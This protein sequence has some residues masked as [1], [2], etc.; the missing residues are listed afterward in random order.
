MPLLQIGLVAVGLAADAFAVSVVEG[1]LI[2]ERKHRHL[3]R[4]SIMFGLF[5]GIMPVLGWTVGRSFER[6]IGPYDH[7]FAFGVLGCL[8]AKMI[9]DSF[10]GIE[11]EVEGEGSRGLRLGALAL[12]TSIDAL[13]VGI[14]VALLDH[15][16]WLPAAG[17]GLITAILCGIGVQ[18]GDRIGTRAGRKAELVGGIVL[19]GLGLKI[20]AEHLLGG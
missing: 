4:L 7:W 19:V 5:Q 16:I 1:V 6:W 10:L 15:E 17:I 2:E 11:S 20:L 12:A 3:L 9:L 8:G 18:A 13:A 14:T